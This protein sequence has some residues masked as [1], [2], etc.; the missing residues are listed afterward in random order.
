MRPLLLGLRDGLILVA[1]LLSVAT[2]LYLI[3]G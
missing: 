2:L 1:A 3:G